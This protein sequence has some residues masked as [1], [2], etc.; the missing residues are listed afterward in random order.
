[1]VLLLHSSTRGTLRRL[2]KLGF[3]ME[4]ETVLDSFLHALGPDG[5]LLL[6]LFNFDFCKGLPFDIRTTPSQMGALTEAGR[7]RSEAVRTGHPVYSFAILG[8]QAN[9]FSRVNNF[10]GYGPDSPFAILHKSGGKV[11]VL[12]LPIRKA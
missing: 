12:D 3:A 2:K 6:P 7:R 10:S 5:T 4:I 1:M 11:A 9:L 8:R